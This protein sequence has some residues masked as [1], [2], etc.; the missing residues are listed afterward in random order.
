[1]NCD[2]AKLRRKNGR[3]ALSANMYVIFFTMHKRSLRTMCMVVQSSRSSRILTQNKGDLF[4]VTSL[5]SRKCGTASIRDWRVWWF[6]SFLGCL[7]RKLFVYMQAGTR[8]PEPQGLTIHTWVFH[9]CK[10][11]MLVQSSRFVCVILA[12]SLYENPRHSSFGSGAPL[13]F[14]FSWLFIAFSSSHCC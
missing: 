2:F 1:M 9:V 11:K 6:P 12:V 10:V 13:D 3:N 8:F 14:Q 7:S 4:E 5:R